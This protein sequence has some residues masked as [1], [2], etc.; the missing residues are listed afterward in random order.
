MDALFRSL[1]SA[2][3]DRVGSIRGA[4]NGNDCA[5]ITAPSHSDLTA[6]GEAFQDLHFVTG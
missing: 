5:G 1:A 6:Y 4:R 2:D 3:A